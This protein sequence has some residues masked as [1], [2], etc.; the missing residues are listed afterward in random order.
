MGIKPVYTFQG[1]NESMPK[2]PVQDPGMAAMQNRLAQRR[3][4]KPMKKPM[5][6]PK[7]SSPQVKSVMPKGA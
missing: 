1:V 6:R 4:N 5:A 3:T 2:N 7:T